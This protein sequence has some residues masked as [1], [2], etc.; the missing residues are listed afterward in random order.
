[1]VETMVNIAKISD[2]CAHDPLIH[3]KSTVTA[4]TSS[5]IHNALR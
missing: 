5:L 1:M 4:R 2:G 3:H